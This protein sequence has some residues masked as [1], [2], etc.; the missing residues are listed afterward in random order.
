MG[1][2]VSSLAETDET[3]PALVILYFFM[4]SFDVISK[5]LILS[6]TLSSNIALEAFDVF[7]D[8]FQMPSKGLFQTK[9]FLTNVALPILTA[10]VNTF[11]MNSKIFQIHDNFVTNITF[12]DLHVENIVETIFSR[13]LYSDKLG[14]QGKNKAILIKQFNSY[15][16]HRATDSASQ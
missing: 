13:L 6:E 14:D 10:L 5:I 11:G 4:N 12:L 15:N 7:V 16:H 9:H 3:N 1:D 2:K 8:H